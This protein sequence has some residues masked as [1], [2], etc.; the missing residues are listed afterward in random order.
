MKKTE[1]FIKKLI[2]L[3]GFIDYKVDLTS[4][5]RG[6]IFIHDNPSL[7]KDNLPL[8]VENINYL[9]QLVARKFG[10]EPVFF[11]VNNY[12]RER[13]NLLTELARAAARKVVATKKEVSLPAMNSY[14]RRIIHIEL[15]MHPDVK[16]EST[17]F[18]K[19][20]FV[21]VKPVSQLAPDGAQQT[22]ENSESQ[23]LPQVASR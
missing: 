5:K 13:E 6:L 15:A 1:E 8:L 9:S 14:E 16:T 12:R 20:R 10:E 17:G 11:D 22:T 19:N 4:E 18:G 2:E 3:A 21:I 7:I 23:N